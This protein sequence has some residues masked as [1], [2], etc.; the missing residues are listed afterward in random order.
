MTKVWSAGVQGSP[1]GKLL[2]ER[3]GAELTR[4]GQVRV[5]P[6]CSLPGHPEVFVVG[7]LMALDSLPGLAEV[8]MQSGMHAAGEIRRRLE[9]DTTPRR[10][11]YRDLGSLAVI[12]RF[13]AIRQR[14]RIHIWGPL[15]WL[16]WLVVHLVFLTG[17]K[18]RVA[19][20]FS[21]IVSFFGRSR[22]ER[23]ITLQQVLARRALEANP[24]AQS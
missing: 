24:P 13:Y 23:T 15:G 7:D 8:A 12:S 16:V 17:F 4:H 3:S 2:A 14:G 6:D 1:L 11:R 10:F 19:A 5:E 9:G 22:Y 21:W 20:L 18:N